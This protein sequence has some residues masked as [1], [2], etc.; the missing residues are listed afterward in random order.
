LL[1]RGLTWLRWLRIVQLLVQ[2]VH[3][4]LYLAKAVFDFWLHID[5]LLVD[6][7]SRP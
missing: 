1:R 4:S 5:A 6:A 7:F 3:L 2:I